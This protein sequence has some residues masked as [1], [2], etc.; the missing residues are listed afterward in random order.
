MLCA[1]GAL[2]DQTFNHNFGAT[3]L[4][5]YILSTIYV[6]CETIYFCDIALEL[7]WSSC[8][9]GSAFDYYS[10]ASPHDLPLGE[11]LQGMLK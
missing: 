6:L 7:A 9:H 8:F 10:M 3:R 1:L 5:P 4:S 2:L 11:E